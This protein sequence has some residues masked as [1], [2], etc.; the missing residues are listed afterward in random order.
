MNGKILLKQDLVLNSAEDSTTPCIKLDL[1]E[2]KEIICLRLQLFDGEQCI[3]HNDYVFPARKGGLRALDEMPETSFITVHKPNG[4]G[5][6]SYL[7]TNVSE[8]PA[9][10][11]HLV[12]RS[13]DGSRILPVLWSDNY[14]HLMPGE[15]REL[16]YIIPSCLNPDSIDID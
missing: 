15:Q 9:L 10:M 13:A 14:I 12:A 6:G 4:D 3:S 5:T 8:V 1:N 7:I 11:L 16:R 2:F